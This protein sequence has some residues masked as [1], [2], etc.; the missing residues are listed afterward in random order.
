ML[1]RQGSAQCN[2][3]ITF[4][5]LHYL[6]K[7]DYKI[8]IKLFSGFFYILQSFN[9]NF[10]EKKIFYISLNTGINVIRM[11]TPQMLSFHDSFLQ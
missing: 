5:Y 7:Y 2:T 3:A 11:K 10:S 6:F 8:Y 9:W 4:F 1:I